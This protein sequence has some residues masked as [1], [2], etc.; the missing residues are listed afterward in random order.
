MTLSFSLSLALKLNI[1]NKRKKRMISPKNLQNLISE[2]F[3]SRKRKEGTQIVKNKKTLLKF[4]F[5][6]TQNLTRILKIKLFKKNQDMK[7]NQVIRNC[8]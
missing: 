7:I 1:K 6:K 4:Q 3:F 5:Q 2:I 8:L